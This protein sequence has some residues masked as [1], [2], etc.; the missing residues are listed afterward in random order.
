MFTYK[1]YLFD[2]DKIKY[3]VFPIYKGIVD[4]QINLIRLLPKLLSF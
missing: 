4:Q 2:S 1:F 3:I